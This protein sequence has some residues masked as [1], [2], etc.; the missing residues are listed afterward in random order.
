MLPKPKPAPAPAAAPVE[1]APVPEPLTIPPWPVESVGPPALVVHG[2]D[3]PVVPVGG[4]ERF[5]A[6]ACRRGEPV[7]LVTDP[8]WN[9]GTVMVETWEDDLAWLVDR[10]EGEPVSNA[11]VE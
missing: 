1:A 8:T 9:H 3:D 2:G 7:D 4:T 6:E 10:L 5:V 11:C